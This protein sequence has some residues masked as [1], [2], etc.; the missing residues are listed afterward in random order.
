LKKTGFYF[1]I[2]KRYRLSVF[3]NRCAEVKEELKKLRNDKVHYMH[4]PQ[5]ISGVIKTDEMAGT[6]TAYGGE[7][8][9]LQG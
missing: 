6:W 8:K 2:W 9:Y 5:N 1:A 4:S 7:E 3:E